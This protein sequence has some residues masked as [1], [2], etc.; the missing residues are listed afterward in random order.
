[1]EREKRV[2]VNEAVS[3]QMF[4]VNVMRLVY[5]MKDERRTLLFVVIYDNT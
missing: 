1:M 5:C 2:P 3:S 4:P